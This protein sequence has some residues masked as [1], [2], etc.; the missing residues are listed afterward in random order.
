LAG[1]FESFFG[2][3]NLKIIDVS[4]TKIDC[5]GALELLSA[6]PLAAQLEELSMG[7]TNADSESI[8]HPTPEVTRSKEFVENIYYVSNT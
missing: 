1:S 4:S 6:K 5:K 8:K 7:N 3:P 2:L